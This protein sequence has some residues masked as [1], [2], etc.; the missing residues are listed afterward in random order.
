MPFVSGCEIYPS[1]PRLSQAQPG[2]AGTQV[3]PIIGHGD[4][5]EVTEYLKDPWAADVVCATNDESNTGKVQILMVAHTRG[6]DYYSWGNESCGPPEA[7]AFGHEFFREASVSV[8]LSIKPLTSNLSGWFAM[9]Y[10]L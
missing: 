4:S 1:P 10:Q 9:L 6:G 8:T 3:G 5:N 7:P 2:L